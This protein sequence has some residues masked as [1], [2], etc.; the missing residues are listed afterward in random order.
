MKHYKTLTAASFALVLLA[1]CGSTGLGDVLGGGGSNQQ[2]YEIRGVVDSVDMNSRSIYLTN[3]SGL[4]SMLSSGNRTAR[5]YYDEQTS[6]AY[7]NRSYRPQ[8]LERGDEVTIRVDESGN[9]LVANQINVTY[10][11]G[12]GSNGSQSSSYSTIRGTVNYIDTSRHTI[13]LDSPSW[14]SGF[15]SSTNGSRMTV[16]YDANAS[17]DVQGRLYPVSNLERGDVVEV[18]V[19]NSN[20]STP[21]AQSIVLVR[22]VNAR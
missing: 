21:F 14:V 16:Y 12:G 18:R 7:Q 15:R 19:N 2:A 1:A 5:V 20:S 11:A 22:D 4:T 17:V 10:D 3:V 6:V 13:E 9:Q 8:D